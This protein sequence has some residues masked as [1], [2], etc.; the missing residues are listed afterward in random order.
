VEAVESSP[1]YL[2]A[3]REL[4]EGD[5]P[6]GGQSEEVFEV[7][8]GDLRAEDAARSARHLMPLLFGR[9]RIDQGRV[10]LLPLPALRYR[11]H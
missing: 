3:V 9:S 2:R 5:L 4:V 8:G 7:E 1:S 11:T 6:A 10:Q